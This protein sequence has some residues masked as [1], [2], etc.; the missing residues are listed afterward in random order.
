MNVKSGVEFCS[1]LV[2]MLLQ[3]LICQVDTQLLKTARRL[4]D[5][6]IILKIVIEH[7]LGDR[8]FTLFLY[9]IFFLFLSGIIS[10]FLRR[11]CVV[12]LLT[13]KLSKP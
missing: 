8:G 3:F 10:Y 6:Q 13:L 12:Y 1:Y 11:T 4:V 7:K 5:H 9:H 2:E